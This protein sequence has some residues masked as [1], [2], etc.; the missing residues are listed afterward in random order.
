MSAAKRSIRSASGAQSASSPHSSKRQKT[1]PNSHVPKKTGL[2]FLVDDDARAGRKLDARPTNGVPKNKSTRVDESHA[3]VAPDAAEDDK[4]SAVNGE[5]QEVIDI[6]SGEESSSDDEEI[7]DQARGE[8]A[9]VNGH[10]ASLQDAELGASDDRMEGVEGTAGTNPDEAEEEQG[11]ASFGD[12]L[13]ARHPDT[14]DV[15][16]SFGAPAE[17][18]ALVPANENR[19]I[20]APSAT[21]LGTVLTQALKTNDKDLLESCFQVTELASIRST[22]QR[23]QSH[24]A[25][26][27]L[28]RLAERIHKRPGR[29][30]NLMVWVQWTLVT[31]GGYLATQPEVMK[32][33]R[34][35]SQVVRERA[36]G[37]Q[38]LLHL[39]GK[40]DLLSA[41]LELR[42]NMQG[43]ARR[44]ADD[45]DDEDA[46]LYI[47]GQDDDWSDDDDDA[48]TEDS[49]DRKLLK[50]SAS[51]RKALTGTPK[52]MAT[53]AD[54]ESDE[55]MP[56]GVAQES[57]EESENEDGGDGQGMFDDEAEET[58]DDDAEEA[59]SADEEQSEQES[60]DETEPS[61]DESEPEIKQPQPKTLNRKR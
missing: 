54:D 1:T 58:S 15:Q 27:L 33:I 24:Q 32:R 19:A 14:I 13:R 37:L 59:S 31:H 39:K 53:E 25:S 41:Q 7:E 30:S 16:A 52:S 28:Q 57:D 6:S 45:E 43:A 61:D 42:R 38:P 40:L 29:T 23:L 2:G 8:G 48:E 10:K 9:L 60:E 56:N 51:K 50:P 34:S 35:L 5:P 49:A 21:S 44:R 11:E 22:I 4:N 26:V 3:L 36:S 47:E 12:M 18:S 20:A 46:V 17:R 55:G